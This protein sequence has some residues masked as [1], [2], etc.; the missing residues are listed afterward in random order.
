LDFIGIGDNGQGMSFEELPYAFTRHATSKI[1]RFEDLYQLYS[2]GFRGEA[3]A[4]IASVAQVTCTSFSKMGEGGKIVLEGGKILSHQK[5]GKGIPGTYIEIRNLFYNTP[6]RLKFIQSKSRDK[7]Q[8]K[9]I[10]DLFVISHPHIAFSIKWDQ[11]AKKFFPPTSARSLLR[12]IAKSSQVDFSKIH[13]EYDHYQL[14]GEIAFNEIKSPQK[15]H[16][17][18]VNDRFFMNNRIQQILKHKMKKI[19]G[20]KFIGP[21][22]LFFKAPKDAIDVNIHPHK[23][24]VNFLEPKII[25]S[26]IDCAIETLLEQSEQIIEHKPAEK[27]EKIE[28]T[29]TTEKV[30]DICSKSLG[31]QI[32]LHSTNNLNYLIS[33]PF[34]KEIYCLNVCALLGKYFVQNL[35]SDF[36]LPESK[37]IPLII[38]T[39]FQLQKKLTQTEKKFFH[40]LG[41]EIDELDSKDSSSPDYILR[42]MCEGLERDL[43]VEIIQQ[44]HSHFNCLIETKQIKDELKFFFDRQFK[45]KTSQPDLIKVQQAISFFG[46]ENLIEEKIFFPLSDQLLSQVELSAH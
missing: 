34:E 26:L 39:P 1:Q 35:L 12:V 31:H 19:W 7:N 45:L 17:L 4:S 22:A 18:F 14:E 8:I 16:F 5:L 42:A 46:E 24:Q 32:N 20:E 23:T 37:Q 9:K 2:F 11:K 29:E 43:A 40:Q 30:L 28:K 38:A 6:V 44:L 3:L 36:P 15:K 41:F 13:V 10:L 21:Y 25:F 33:T 27:A